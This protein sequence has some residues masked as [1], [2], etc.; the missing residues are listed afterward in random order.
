MPPTLD[1]LQY[2]NYYDATVLVLNSDK[3]DTSCRYGTDMAFPSKRSIEDML[4]DVLVFYLLSSVFN[5]V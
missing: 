4:L 2:L 3:A 1:K 5:Y